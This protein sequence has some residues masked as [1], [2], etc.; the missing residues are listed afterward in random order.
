MPHFDRFNQEAL[1]RAINIYLDV[2]RPFI[3]D[4]LQY[5]Y[6]TEPLAS[7][8]IRALR[9]E[10]T[11]NFRRS[12][13]FGHGAVASTLDVAHFR[14]VVEFYWN[15]I[16][17][18]IF[19]NDTSVLG[20]LGWITR[21]R[22]DVA[23][24]GIQDIPTRDAIDHCN[25]ILKILRFIDAPA[26]ENAVSKIREN[27]ERS[28]V[29][30]DTGQ[31]A[32]EGQL[33]SLSTTTPAEI[34]GLNDRGLE[35]LMKDD[36]SRAFSYFSEVLLRDPDNVIAL[37]NRGTSLIAA[38]KFA[39]A[40]PDLIKADRMKPGNLDIQRQLGISLQYTGDLVSALA[41]YRA[42]LD[43][44][45]DNVF[46][47][48]RK[49][50]AYF[51]CGDYM[52]SIAA[53][54][55]AL[56]IDNENRYVLTIRGTAHYAL[57][58]S[59]LADKDF[60]RLGPIPNALYSHC[61]DMLEAQPHNAIIY[62]NRGL[63]HQQ[64]ASPYPNGEQMDLAEADFKSA[65]QIAPDYAEVIERIGLIHFSRKEYDLAKEAFLKAIR[66][67]ADLW[68]AYMNLARTHFQLGEYDEAIK[69][70]S[71]T[72]RS[73]GTAREYFPHAY[74]ERGRAYFQKGEYP[75]AI[76]D[77]T[78]AASKMQ[79]AYNTR[80]V[81]NHAIGKYNEAIRDYNL[82]IGWGPGNV[83]NYYNLGNSYSRKGQ[84]N[85]AEASYTKAIQLWESDADS[86]HDRGYARYRLGMLDEALRDYDT[87]IRLNPKK[88]YFYYRRGIA[89][90]DA[91]Q[92]Q[93]ALDDFT[94]A[95]SIDSEYSAAYQARGSINEDLGYDKK[96]IKDY[97]EGIRLNPDNALNHLSRGGVYRRIRMERLASRDFF[98]AVRLDPGLAETIG[99]VPASRWRLREL[100]ILLLERLPIQEFRSKTFFKKR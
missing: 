30:P 97:T 65:L 89:L 98:N 51:D 5:S 69:N 20:T 93:R 18:S 84:L 21:A 7:L 39:E 26:A 94:E 54:T 90:K 36:H 22:N 80:G 82:A 79:E 87:A 72:I 60:K 77:F 49:C 12:L 58:H 91:G 29:Q 95:I 46:I 24:P 15:E 38:Y 71:V 8:V 40:I 32:P 96:A 64:T 10:Q 17:G 19:R 68:G 42:Y 27:L 88:A 43:V 33:Q 59:V 67:K 78:Q 55:A 14:P 4:N 70:C 85:D 28:Y 16:F 53:C 3:L 92:N 44:A 62:F 81:V 74:F 31:A 56:K 66:I 75:A 41:F 9:S 37:E 63:I 50:L 99:V 52:Q 100:I 86:Y 76:S 2:M 73:S 35:Y 13:E 23:H 61:S 57:G 6:P 1:N 25:N 34:D 48:E 83:D 11:E 47:H 45:P